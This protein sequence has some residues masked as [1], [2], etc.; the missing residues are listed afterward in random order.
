MEKQLCFFDII[1]LNHE[2]YWWVVITFYIK[3]WSKLF[4][5]GTY[6]ALTIFLLS[7]FLL[8]N[9]SFTKISEANFWLETWAYEGFSLFACGKMCNWVTDSFPLYKVSHPRFLGENL[10]KNKII[11]DRIE[12]LARKHHCSPAQLALAWVLEQGDDVVPIPGE[13]FTLLFFL[14]NLKV[15]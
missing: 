11:Y 10:N 3:L 1:C 9:S 4:F 8:D 6:R 5:T 7:M 12:T 2:S 15:L 14:F 13:W